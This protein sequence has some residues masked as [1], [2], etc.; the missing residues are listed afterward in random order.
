[1][2]SSTGNKF[3]STD[4]YSEDIVREFLHDVDATL[5][6]DRSVDPCE[7]NAVLKS[8]DDDYNITVILSFLVLFAY[9]D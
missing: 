1:M 6:E 2:A 8:A 5:S 4:Q 7:A 9:N 3:S